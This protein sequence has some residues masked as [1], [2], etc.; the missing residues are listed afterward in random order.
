MGWSRWRGPRGWAALLALVAPL[1]SGGC[2]GP[3]AVSG[4]VSYN[5]TPLRGGQVTFISAE[6]GH[7]VSSS[8]KQDGSYALPR[9]PPGKVKICVDTESL[10]PAGKMKFPNYR[11]P[12]G[13]DGPKRR[14]PDE[15]ADPAKLYVR[16]PPKYSKPEESPLSYEVTS[17]AQTHDIKLD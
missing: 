10:N 9:V 6:G 14:D 4:K 1:G 13:V 2:G 8:I 16:I 17:G 12:P 5:G 15:S 7:T 11:P 3:G